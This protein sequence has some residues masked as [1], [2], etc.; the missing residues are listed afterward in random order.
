MA[1]RK[2]YLIEY[3]LVSSYEGR[4]VA[5]GRKDVVWDGTLAGL[6]QILQVIGR[7]LEQGL[8]PSHWAHGA[9]MRVQIVS[10]VELW[11]ETLWGG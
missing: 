4:S 10:M 5:T 1:E 9:P 8:H 6:D 7:E 2:Q 3:N 11:G